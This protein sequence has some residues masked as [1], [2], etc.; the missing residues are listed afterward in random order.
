MIIILFRIGTSARSSFQKN[1]N[2]P[3]PGQY[4]I[5][6]GVMGPKWGFGT[7]LRPRT[8]NSKDPGPGTY[9]IPPTFA[10][11]PKYLISTPN[12]YVV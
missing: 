1:K 12:K 4:D 5:R 6:G 3:G 10:D 9:L 7:G 8:A 11:V 2:S